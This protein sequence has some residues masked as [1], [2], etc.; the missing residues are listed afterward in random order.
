[1][2][3]ESIH[4]GAVRDMTPGSAHSPEPGAKPWRSAIVKSPIDGRVHVGREGLNG[5]A[6]ENRK[7]HGGPEMAMLA[8]GSPSRTRWRDEFGLDF[9]PGGFGENLLISD[10]D[11]SSVCIGDVYRLGD[12]VVV[13]VSQPRAPC[14]KLARRWGRPSLVQ[15]VLD[16]GRSGWYLRV[17]REGDIETGQ[18]VALEDRPYPEITVRAVGDVAHAKSFDPVMLE[19]IAACEALSASWREQAARKIEQQRAV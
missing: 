10:C 13:Q 1:M 14:W 4:V 16:T 17:L 9:P 3:I 11:E 7:H 8:Y 19:R 15:E 12:E 6:Q 18:P 2:R 5:D